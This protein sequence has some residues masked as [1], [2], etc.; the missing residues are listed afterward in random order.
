MGELASTRLD[1]DGAQH[2]KLLLADIDEPELLSRVGKGLMDGA[3]QCRVGKTVAP[4]S[5]NT[6]ILQPFLVAFRG[7]REKGRTVRLSMMLDSVT[8]RESTVDSSLKSPDGPT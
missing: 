5:D 8:T 6:L 1:A 4:L 2:L 3:G 7:C